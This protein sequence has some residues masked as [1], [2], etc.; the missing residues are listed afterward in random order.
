[1]RYL[2]LTD[3]DRQ[4]MLGVIGAKTIDDLFVDV[5]SGAQ[6]DGPIHGLPNHAPTSRAKTWRRR[7]I[8]SFWV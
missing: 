8:R 2:P 3:I 4:A 6:L 1:M 7:I 5:P